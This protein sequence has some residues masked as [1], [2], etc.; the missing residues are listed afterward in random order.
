[1]ALARVA[2]PACSRERLLAMFIAYF[3]ESGHP[4]DTLV[5]TMAG[6]V[7]TAKNWARFEEKWKRILRRY[8]VSALHMTDYESGHGE[9]TGWD[10]DKR[11]SFIA[12]LAGILK[13]T[14]M[15]GVANSLTVQD[16]NGTIGKDLDASGRKRYLAP[17]VMLLESCITT[18]AESVSIPDE[19]N[20]ACVFDQNSIV[21]HFSSIFYRALV[22][23]RD[24]PINFGTITYADRTKIVPLQAADM[25]AYEAFKYASRWDEHTEGRPRR[26]LLRNLSATGCMNFGRF[27]RGDFEDFQS[28]YRALLEYQPEEES[29]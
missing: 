19:E 2:H 22:E 26:K 4:S 7:A 3:D 11:V 8:Q 17:Y 28:K 27:N 10:A 12:D 14:M 29:L 16:W 18:I 25:I 9:F 5:M 20:V 1:M 24:Y 6:V 13:N 15:Y 21:Q 23:V